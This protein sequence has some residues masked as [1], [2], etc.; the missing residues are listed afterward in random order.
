M[1][2]PNPIETF[3]LEADDLLTTIEDVVL[4]MNGGAVNDDAVNQLF[5]AF[6][7]LKGS[8]AMFDFDDVAEFT[9]HVEGALDLVRNGRLEVSPGLLD[10]VLAAKDLIKGMLQA[11]Q[12]G[13]A[14]A[15]DA[16]SRIVARLAALSG[17][18]TATTAA[19]HAAASQAAATAAAAPAAAAGAAAVDY[20]ISFR[21]D[22]GILLRGTNVQA[23][24]DELRALGPCRVRALT[25]AVPPLAT[26]DAEQ[27]FVHWDIELRTAAGPNA[28]RD[29]FLFVEDGSDLR[30]EA[31]A[32]SAATAVAEAPAAPVAG[33]APSAP[34]SS[35]AKEPAAPAAVPGKPQAKD[36]MI[37]VTSEKLDRLVNLVGEL[38]MNQSRLQ[39]VAARVDSADLLLSVEQIERLI[40]ELRDTV[41]GIRMM[42]IGSTFGRFKRL[43]H[44]LSAEL[45]KEVDLVT[46]GAD[47]EIDKT[48]LDQLADPL[49]HLI[50][51]SLDHGIEPAEVRVQRGKLARGTIRLSAAHQGSN[52]VVRIQD[53]GKGL[54]RAAILRKGIERGLVTADATPS[55]RDIF[56]LIFLPGFSTAAQV[57]SVSGRG[58]GMDVVKRQIE[59]LRGTVSLASEPGLGTTVTC[60]LPLT[61]AIVDGLAVAVGEA[62]YVIPTGA[63]LEN[64]EL[65]R[66]E[67]G[68][69]NGRQ[70]VAVRGEL[71]PYI[72]LRSM[73][74]L[75][76]GGP[77]V[78]KVVIVRHAEQRVGIVVDRVLGSHQTVIQPLGRFCRGI[79]MLSGSTI[80]GDGRVALI[81]DVAGLV[82]Q[83]AAATASGA[84]GP[85]ATEATIH[86]PATTSP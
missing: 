29:V 33:A 75:D 45:G 51:N 65:Q 49:I 46:E 71:V 67:R 12:G 35:P 4:D 54:D 56:N 57:T 44:D 70:V 11:R 66:E 10:C 8:G 30:I 69:F 74:G 41:L 17:Q 50:R 72:R 22:P 77:D 63:V 86:Q 68:A 23:L 31:V 42:P 80:M 85:T 37:R 82:R 62:Q 83:S 40:N 7:T 36:A 73:C 24:F 3:L 59:G 53:N 81:L 55:D 1:A 25:D 16:G 27:C 13:A 52:V 6:H 43:V 60:T 58:V 14:V 21:P 64:V 48:V 26:L 47:T 34:S 5:R 84:V 79:E 32:A 78:E 38:V 28:I 18:S 2:Q 39:Q 20:R 15:A 76:G 61:L 9:H 19:S